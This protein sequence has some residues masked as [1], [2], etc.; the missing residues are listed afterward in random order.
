MDPP[1]EAFYLRDDVSGELLEPDRAADPAIGRPIP[2]GMVSRYSLFEHRHGDIASTLL[3][4]VPPQDLVKISRLTLVNSFDRQRSVSITA[5]VECGAGNRTRCLGALPG[6]AEGRYHR[7]DTCK[8][9]HGAWDLPNARPLADLSGEQTSW[10][11]D[12]R[13]FLGDNGD[14]AARA[15]WRAM[16]PSSAAA[17]RPRILARALQMHDRTGAGRSKGDRFLPGAM[18]FAGRSLYV[19][20]SAL[21]CLDLD[22]VLTV[23]AGWQ[24]RLEAVQVTTPDRAMDILLNG[25]L[26]YQTIS[27][28]LLGRAPLSTRSSGAYGFRDQLQ[29]KGGH[30]LDL[31]HAGGQRAASCC[32]PRPRQF[33]S[34]ATY[35]IGGLPNR[36]WG[37][38]PDFRMIAGVA[39]RGGPL[40]TEQR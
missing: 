22:E 38:D 7:G 3:Q 21:P 30:G 35:S 2:R 17:A 6:Y 24:A 16:R 34:K 5:Y 9:I 1:G 37:T 20:D 18:R 33:A 40:C 12:R 27:C 29:D 19:A 4:Y 14:L 28:R 26:L 15:P 25:W 39:R 36:D 32:A 8:A 23:K 10:T 11:G 31:R 13:E